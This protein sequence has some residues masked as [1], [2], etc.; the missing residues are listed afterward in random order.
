VRVLETAKPGP[1]VA[2]S[3]WLHL[4]PG[5]FGISFTGRAYSEPRLIELAYGFEQA[6]EWRQPSQSAP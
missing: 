5:P 4:Y 3:G 6:T 1:W 2:L